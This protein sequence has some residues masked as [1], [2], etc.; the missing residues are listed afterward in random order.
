MMISN[1][2]QKLFSVIIF[3]S[4]FYQEIFQANTNI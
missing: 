2:N 1:N 3:K 4:E